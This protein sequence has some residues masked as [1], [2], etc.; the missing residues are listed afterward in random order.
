TGNVIAQSSL[1]SL[2]RDADLRARLVRIAIL[3]EGKGAVGGVP[4]LGKRGAEILTLLGGTFHGSELRLAAECVIKIGANPL[5]LRGPGGQRI[6]LSGGEHVAHGKRERVEIVL[7]AEELERVSAIAIGELALQLL[8]SAN[9]ADDVGRVGDD[10]GERQ[11]E[12]E[13]E[14]CGRRA[15]G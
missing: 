12:A 5:K 10:S 9:L 14:S 15:L 6:G 11:D 13:K 4:E 1:A 8:Q 7:N 2:Q 3:G